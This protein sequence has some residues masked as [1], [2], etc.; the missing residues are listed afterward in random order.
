MSYALIKYLRI[1]IYISP[2]NIDRM[3]T[4]IFE[5]KPYQEKY[6]QEVLYVWERSVLTTH[7]F[8]SPSD[9]EEIKKLVWSFDFNDLQVYCL[10][11]ERLVPGFMGVDNGKIEMLFLDP[12]YFGQGLGSMLLAFAV[13]TLAAD[14]LDVNEQNTKALEFYRKSG[15]EIF[16]RSDRDEQGRGYPIIRMRLKK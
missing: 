1:R 4:T 12:A 14:R 3:L 16:D 15:F 8:L 9:F 7:H 11:K 2:I 5:I 6:R 13:N 10:E